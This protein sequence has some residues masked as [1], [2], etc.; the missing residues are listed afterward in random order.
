MAHPNQHPAPIVAPEAAV[1]SVRRHGDT[2]DVYAPRLRQTEQLGRRVL[3]TAALPTAVE[4]FNSYP[5]L[6]YAV[7][8]PIYVAAGT[9][10]AVGAY[11]VRR[12][13]QNGKV[14]RAE[15]AQDAIRQDLGEPVDVLRVG[16]VHGRRKKNRDL[17][18]RWY[19]LDAEYTDDSKPADAF[20]VA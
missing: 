14:A 5:G 20:D 7:T 15:A 9:A 4:A 16:R 2:L 6:Q 1:A 13:R 17:N 8:A 10:V 18:L 12:L 19:G 11:G 3:L